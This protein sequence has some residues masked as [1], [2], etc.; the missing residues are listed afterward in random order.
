MADTATPDTGLPRTY[1]K[2]PRVPLDLRALLIAL[3][4]YGVYRLG[5][6]LLW[7]AFKPVDPVQ[8]FFREALSILDVPYIQ[9]ELGRFIG[10]VFLGMSEPQSRSKSSSTR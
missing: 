5:A 3:V 4:G 8:A 10:E 1:F 2:A 6:Y 9:F 7:L